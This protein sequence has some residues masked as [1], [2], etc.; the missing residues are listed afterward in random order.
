[1]KIVKIPDDEM[2][3]ICLKEFRLL[4]GMINHPNIVK[5]HEAFYNDGKETMYLVMD[6]ISGSSLF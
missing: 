6:F 1:V 2:K 5:M 3:E 4:K